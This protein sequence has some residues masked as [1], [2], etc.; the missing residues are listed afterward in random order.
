MKIENKI[1]I[2]D[3]DSDALNNYARIFGDAGYNVR[4]ATNSTE[5]YEVLNSYTPDLILL[6]LVLKDESGYDILKKIKSDAR[7]EFIYVVIISGI[8]KTSAD[9]SEGLEQGA[10]GFIIRPI[11]KREL[12]ARIDAFLRHKRTL[13]DLRINKE[14]FSAI[15]NNDPDATLIINRAGK[16]VFVNPSAEELF[17]EPAEK[18]IDGDFGFPTLGSGETEIQIAK[19][20]KIIFGEMRSIQINWEDDI[21][22]LVSIRDITTRKEDENK[23]KTFAAELQSVIEDKDKFFSILA[24]DLRSPFNGLLGLTDLIVEDFNSFTA[25]E[26]KEYN[27]Q[28]NEA[29]HK[30]YQ[31]LSDLMEWGKLQNA[32]RT[33]APEKISLRK[34]VD[35][36]FGQVSFSAN[37]KEIALVNL[38]MDSTTLFAEKNMIK[39]ILRNLISN[40]IKF[41]PRGGAV[42]TSATLNGNCTVVKI[43]DTGVGMSQEQ[44]KKLFHDNIRVSTDGTEKEKGTGFGLL[45]CKELI[46]KFKGKI[47]CESEIGKGSNFY[48]SLPCASVPDGEKD[49]I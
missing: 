23:I 3:D 41:T 49:Y 5:I 7:Y 19:Q 40:A 26:L 39:L 33:L 22:H 29:L 21:A 24:H 12:L 20:D 34:L 16:I 43:S 27:K 37:A 44:I 9:Q 30:Q 45:I 4:T 1:L 42:K 28:I 13:D 36:I 35:E 38:I 17:G 10:D 8:L 32:K 2:V 15:I 25:E 31:L 11:E 14:R 47:W 46:Q 6:D 48:F 18:L